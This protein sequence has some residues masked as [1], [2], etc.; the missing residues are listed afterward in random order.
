MQ[1]P[2]KDAPS[3]PML[4]GRL[5]PATQRIAGEFV[6]DHARFPFQIDRTGNAQ[7]SSARR[8]FESAAVQPV[9]AISPDAR[10]LHESFNR[11][12]GKTRLLLFL[13]PT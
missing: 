9:I 7:I 6:H 2:E 5:D 1:S 13:S 10:E 11:D 3:M 8:A 12:V 4:A